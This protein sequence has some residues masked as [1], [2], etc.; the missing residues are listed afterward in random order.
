VY[1]QCHFGIAGISFLPNAGI[2]ND[3]PIAPQLIL[4]ELQMANIVD[5]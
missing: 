1:L 5:E 3:G 4:K 2:N